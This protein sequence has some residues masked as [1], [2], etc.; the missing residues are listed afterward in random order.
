MID[1]I[2]HNLYTKEIFMKKLIFIILS[3]AIIVSGC[4]GVAPTQKAVAVVLTNDK[5]QGNCIA[6]GEVIGS[7]GN[8]FSGI[9][10]SNGKI[11]E[12]ARNIVRNKAVMLGGNVVHIQNVSNAS[13]FLSNGTTNTLVVGQVYKCD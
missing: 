1:R 10:M 9:F 5:P 7:R 2:L 13:A 11:M 8:F 12:G 3:A 4:A 6:L